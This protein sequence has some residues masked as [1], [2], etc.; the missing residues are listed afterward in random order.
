MNTQASSIQ[1]ECGQ[2]QI[3]TPTASAWE[4]HYR[5]SACKRAGTIRWAHHAPPPTYQRD[6]QGELF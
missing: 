1:C 6:A 4:F 3:I 2:R 5:C